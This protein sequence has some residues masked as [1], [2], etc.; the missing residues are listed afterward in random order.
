VHWLLTSSVTRT[1]CTTVS[2]NCA[3]W[4]HRGRSLDS[5]FSGFGGAS[6]S[7]ASRDGSHDSDVSVSELSSAPGA[8]PTTAGSS[9]NHRSAHSHSYSLSHAASAGGAA[10]V[11]AVESDR[12]PLAQ[13]PDSTLQSRLQSQRSR[14]RRRR[15]ASLL[16]DVVQRGHTVLGQ[17]EGSS[18]ECSSCCS[19]SCCSFSCSSVLSQAIALTV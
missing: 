19:C 9:T 1:H 3:V 13:A 4:Q 17:I 7:R 11:D 6:S 2:I 16:D 14:R 15:R 12:I 8:A 18:G 10:A 5:E